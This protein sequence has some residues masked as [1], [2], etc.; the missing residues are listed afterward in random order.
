M[1][2]WVFRNYIVIIPT[3]SQLLKRG[4]LFLGINLFCITKAAVNT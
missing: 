3:A 4:A 1:E 2:T